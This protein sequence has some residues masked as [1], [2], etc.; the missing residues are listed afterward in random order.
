MISYSI[1]EA[2]T[3]HIDT[4]KEHFKAVN[5]NRQS[6]IDNRQSAKVTYPLFDILFGTLCS[7]IAGARGWFDIHEYILGHH[8]WFKQ[9]GL[10]QEGYP[11]MTPLLV[12][13]HTLN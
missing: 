3:M 11:S 10:F 9:L 4:F 1:F 2:K 5:D 8:D 13:F 6:T 7:V 12:L